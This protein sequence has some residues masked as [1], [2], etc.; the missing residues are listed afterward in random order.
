MATVVRRSLGTV[1]DLAP[2]E[3]TVQAATP[4]R[5]RDVWYRC[6]QCGATIDLEDEQR[7]H[8]IGKDGTVS[9][10]FACFTETCSAIDWLVLESFGLELP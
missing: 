2:G 5:A 4:L 6:H 1:A 8:R 7:H 10:R 9:P 3:Y